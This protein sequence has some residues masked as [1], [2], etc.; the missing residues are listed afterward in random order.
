[1][2][3][4]PTVRG[5][6][7]LI[8]VATSGFS[9]FLLLFAI[10]NHLLVSSVLIGIA[11]FCMV[12][13]MIASQTLAQ[14]LVAEELRGRVMSIYSMISIGMLPFGS[15]LSGVLADELT[16]RWAFVINALICFTSA[17]Y[18]GL[19]LPQLRRF[20]HSTQEFQQAIAAEKLVRE[21]S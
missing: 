14:T 8:I 10:S 1:M 17:G 4:R 16:V 7:R 13:T 19:K 15:L 5:L 9:F 21:S 11:G 2:A 12:M 6:G 3:M 20:A 18:F